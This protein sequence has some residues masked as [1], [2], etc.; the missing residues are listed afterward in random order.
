MIEVDRLKALLRKKDIALR[1]ASF[2]LREL[3]PKDPDAQMTV[4]MIDAALA[5]PD[6]RRP[7]QDDQ[8]WVYRM[9]GICGRRDIPRGV[10][11]PYWKDGK[12]VHAYCD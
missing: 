8:Q 4:R 2:C 7:E 9:C 6:S 1:Q 11:W 12:P 10:D 5:Q 3:L